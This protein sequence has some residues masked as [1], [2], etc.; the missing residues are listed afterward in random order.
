MPR[1]RPL[2]RNWVTANRG[3]LAGIGRHGPKAKIV[4][5]IA[6]E[7][8]VKEDRVARGVQIGDQVVAARAA[9]PGMRDATKVVRAA[10]GGLSKGSPKSSWRN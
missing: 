3:G 8:V 6:A 9:A 7:I 4:E 5:R 1:I 2:R 10:V